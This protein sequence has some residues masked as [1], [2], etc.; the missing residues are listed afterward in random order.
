MGKQRNGS[1]LQTKRRPTGLRELPGNQ[2]TTALVK[3]H[4]ANP[5]AEIEALVKA[6]QMQFL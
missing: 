6:Q 3:S 1:N 4:G 2:V 5:R